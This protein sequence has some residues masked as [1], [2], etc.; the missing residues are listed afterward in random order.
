MAD[1]FTIMSTDTAPANRS[2]CE[3]LRH[4][5]TW[6]KSLFYAGAERNIA[7]FQQWSKEP[8]MQC[9]T[10]R[11]FRRTL[12]RAMFA[13]LTEAW[14]KSSVARHTFAFLPDWKPRSLPLSHVSAAAERTLIRCCF[15][16]NDSRTSRHF[17]AS[18][19]STLCRHCNA[20]EET[21]EHL[22]LQCTSLD[23]ARKTL[24]K[25]VPDA[26][27]DFAFLRTILLDRQYAIQSQ[28]F[29]DLAL[30]YEDPETGA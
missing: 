27:N 18:Q 1:Y 4:S 14:A 6:N 24:K 21:I 2:Q 17:G 30:P 25:V 22:F 9:M 20:A 26:D 12:E 3:H 29:V 8:L 15:A 7:Y 28:R 13:E 5:A 23:E 10:R 16:H 11:A 19:E